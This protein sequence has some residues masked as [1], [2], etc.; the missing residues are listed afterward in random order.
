MSGPRVAAVA[1]GA[2]AGALESLSVI[3]PELPE[4][5]PL[6]VL[7]VVHLPP[8]RKSL[9]AS[10]LRERCRIAV[11]EA[12]DKERIVGGMVY[13]APPDYHLMVEEDRRLSL[14]SEEPVRYSRP[15][16][17]VLFE[18]AAEAYGPGLVGIVLSGANSDGARGLRA[19]CDAGGVGLVQSPDQALASAMPHAALLA[20]P[21]AAAMSLGEIAKHLLGI[22]GP[23]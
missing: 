18:T 9:M 4:D 11:K 22:V 6:P 7:V 19:I 14:S 13:L 15:S 3:L 2:S 12:E 16:I 17:D 10:L 1:V 20:C 21:E 23:S 8:D 5:Y